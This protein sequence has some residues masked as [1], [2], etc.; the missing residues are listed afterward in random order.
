MSHDARM[1]GR[2]HEPQ[3]RS[4]ETHEAWQVPHD[5][6]DPLPYAEVPTMAWD[7]ACWRHA[8]VVTRDAQGKTPVSVRVDTAVVEESTHQ[9]KGSLTWRN[10]V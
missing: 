5:R 2:R 9:G 7:E 6:E 1:D 4:S 10:A 8:R 3:T